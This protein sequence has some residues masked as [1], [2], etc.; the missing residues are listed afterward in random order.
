VTRPA[1]WRRFLVRGVFW[2][3][4]LRF[5]V[6]NVPIWIEPVIIASWSL[7]FLVWGPGRRGVMSNLK[8]IKPGSRSLINFFRC[9]RVF[10]NFAWTMTDNVRFKEYR[11]VPDWEFTGWEHFQ[12]MQ[13]SSAAILL[14]AHMGS[15]D[16]GAQLF[17]ETSGRRI[18]IIRAPE[19]DPQTRAF[20]ETHGAAALQVQFNINPSELALDLLH[21]LRDGGIVAIQGDRVS[22]GISDLP[23]TLFGQSTRLPAGPFALALAARVPIHPTFIVRVGRRRYRLIASPPILVA[24]TCDRETAFSEAAATWARELET[25]IRAWWYQWF[26]FEPFSPELDR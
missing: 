10:W 9:Y 12:A 11:V 3:Q 26:M 24:Q 17:S 19:M 13:Q 15:Y 4:I 2:R 8:A 21:A 14:T 20:E 25:V 7:F 1:W 18:I 23:A 6:C 5:A 16:L 22:A